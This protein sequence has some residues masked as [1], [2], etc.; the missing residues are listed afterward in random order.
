MNRDPEFTRLALEH[1]HDFVWLVQEFLERTLREQR[2][3]LARLD[4]EIG[5][6]RAH[7]VAGEEYPAVAAEVARLRAEYYPPAPVR[8]AP[9]IV[10]AAAPVAPAAAAADGEEERPRKRAKKN[11]R[12]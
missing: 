5:R 7:G 3:R 9:A 2:L 11:K 1:G 6:L 10:A 8:A 4:I 12:A